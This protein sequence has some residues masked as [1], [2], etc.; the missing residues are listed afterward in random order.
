[1]IV[2]CLI[3]LQ[4]ISD[5]CHRQWKCLITY[6]DRFVS[7]NQFFAPLFSF[8]LRGKHGRRSSGVSREILLWSSDHLAEVLWWLARILS[9]R[10]DRGGAALTHEECVAGTWLWWD[11]C[12]FQLNR[13]LG[14]Q[15]VTPLSECLEW[16]FVTKELFVR[17][18]G[19]FKLF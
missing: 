12:P 17:W 16:G 8:C 2:I 18:L 19:C 4:L 9:Y 14:A 7:I 15:W 5:I 1:M 10:K 6:L 3:W 11:R 13:V